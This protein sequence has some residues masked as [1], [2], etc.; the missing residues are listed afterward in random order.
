MDIMEAILT[1]RSIREFT[2]QVIEEDKL[3]K[4][5]QAGFQ[6]PSA[7]NKEPREFVVVKDRKK[8]K[9][10]TDFH[11]Y[12]QMLPD[13]GCGII[14]CGDSSKQDLEG[15]LIADCSAAIQNILLAAHGLELGAVWCGLYPRKALMANMGRVLNLP[16]NIMPVGLV[17]VGYKAEEKE[18][19]DRYNQDCI[20]LNSW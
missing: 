4:L 6:A 17:A 11:E 3:K 7:H 16:E 10:I 9:E 2:G 13:A 8:I 19:I 12:A 1:R 20:H 14:V 15:F 18:G 5:L